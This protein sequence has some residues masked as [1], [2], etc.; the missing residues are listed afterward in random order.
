MDKGMKID[1]VAKAL[2]ETKNAIDLVLKIRDIA[3]TTATI[4][5]QEHAAELRGKLIDIKEYLIDLKEENLLIKK[6]NK[7][8][9]NEDT[10]FEIER[11]GKFYYAK[12]VEEPICFVCSTKELAPIILKNTSNIAN[13]C[14]KCKS[15]SM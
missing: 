13:V 10:R 12:G 4:E 8:L 9:K 3:M 15:V 14:P 6:E 2:V 1:K 5:L 7:N 11:K